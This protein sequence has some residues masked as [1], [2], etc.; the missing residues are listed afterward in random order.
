MRKQPNPRPY[1]LPKSIAVEN[2]RR[3]NT[4][5]ADKAAILKISLEHFGRNGFEGTSV[6]DI[7]Q[8]SGV[9]KPMLYYHFETKQKLWYAALRYAAKGLFAEFSNLRFE[10]RG[11]PAIDALGVAIRRYTYALC[12]DNRALINVVMQEVGRGG[13]RS[14]WL[15]QHYMK[16]M[17]RITEG[18]LREA[19]DSGSLRPIEPVRLMSLIN[20]AVNGFFAFSAVL[21]NLYQLDVHS[22]K[23]AETHAELVIDLL[24]NGLMVKNAYTHMAS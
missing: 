24:L 15:Q 13:E 22:K 5:F 8:S 2:N 17:Y 9:A 18:F 14:Q 7:A 16:P 4:D 11:L 1:T 6:E 3:S 20:G 10:L 21:E 19:V 12:V 23:I